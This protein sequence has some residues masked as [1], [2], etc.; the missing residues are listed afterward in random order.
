M[1][2]NVGNIDMYIRIILAVIIAALGYY[3]QSWWGLLAIVPLATAFLR[4]CPAW[5]IFGISTMEKQKK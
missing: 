4:F 2:R 5:A 1:K 3:F